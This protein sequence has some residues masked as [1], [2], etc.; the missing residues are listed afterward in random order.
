[1]FK[2]INSGLGVGVA[3]NAFIQHGLETT[4]VEI[5]PAVFDAATVFFGL[6]KPA[7]VHFEDA[8]TWVAKRAAAKNETYDI[9]VHDLFSGGGVPAHLYTLEFWEDLKRILS[10]DGGGTRIEVALPCDS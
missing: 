9:I 7:S 8:R 4:V 2:Q 10:P 1:M 6:S 3:A 5:D